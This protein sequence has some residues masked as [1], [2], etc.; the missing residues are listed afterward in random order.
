MTGINARA[1]LVNRILIEVDAR[2]IA[3][4]NL[5]LI[6]KPA[7]LEQEKLAV[8]RAHEQVQKDLTA[9]KELTASPEV[10]A[11]I[12]ALVNDIVV[13]EQAYGP[14]ALGIVQLALQNKRD[15]AIA[16]M[17]DECRPLLA[18]LI[19]KSQAYAEVTAKRSAAMVKEAEEHY[20]IQRNWL[21]AACLIA[22]VTAVLTGAL[23]VRSLTR[24]L[25][26][27]PGFLGQVAQRVAEGDLANLAG[28]ATA[29]P[30]SVLESLGAMQQSLV[31]IVS[32]VR[33]AA[34]SI[35]T[36]SAQI[37][38]GNTDLSQRTEEQASALQQTAATMDEFGNTVRLNADNAKTASEL[39]HNASDVASK[40]GMVVAQVV[41][42]MKGINDSSKKI[43]DIIGVIDG[44][45]F[46]T[47]ILALNAAVEAARAGEQGRGFAVVA[48]EVRSLAGRSAEAAKEIK[49]LIGASV[50]QVEQGTMLV[51]K[52]GQTM[53]E[54]VTAI[55][56]VSHIV[57]EI[58]LA[59]SEQSSGVTQIGQAINQLDQTT[60][61]NSALVEES[62][63]A[64]QSR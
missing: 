40:G 57:S 12:K 5:V 34:D 63:A 51:D 3:A 20:R 18:E 8:T 38:S 2:A 37:S 7:E 15:E 41:E 26:A 39:A 13:V 14:V 55:A 30:D 23:I 44:I 35:A 62:A 58:S 43:G 16:K 19:K 32:Q 17:N 36:G 47:N 60:Q 31:Q 54:V 49:A 11:D 64:A 48:S 33:G 52:A 29:P 56:R 27:E 45:A 42:T 1:S 10:P 53:E 61:Q 46:Q 4:R 21:V 28:A 25:G 24:A 22:V 6:T 9:L 59:S 50:E